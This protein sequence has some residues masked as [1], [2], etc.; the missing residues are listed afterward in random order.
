MVKSSNLVFVLLFAFLLRLERPTLRLIG[1]IS[2]MTIGVV[3]MVASETEF[4]L[5]GFLLA[6]TAAMLSGLRWSIT[7]ILLKSNEATSNPFSTIFFLAPIMGVTLFAL[8]LPIEGLLDFFEA[9]IWR[10]ESFG[11]WLLILVAPGV[12]AF[13]MTTAE[14]FLLNRTNVVTLSI[15][16]IFKEVLTIGVSA[17]VYGDKLTAVNVSGLILTLIAIAFYN[18]FRIKSMHEKILHAQKTPQT[19]IEVETGVI[20]RH[21]YA[22]IATNDADESFEMQPLGSVAED[23]HEF[24]LEQKRAY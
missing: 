23:E 22:P 1:I 9:P 5:I 11:M 3:M 18:Y 15:V 16:G 12:I 4:V 7:Q 20:G 6:F 10:E 24:D 17:G 19:D 2:L 13:L 21:T 14:F 8:A